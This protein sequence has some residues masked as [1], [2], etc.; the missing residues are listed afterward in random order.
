MNNTFTVEC[1]E[2]DEGLRLDQCIVRHVPDLH[3]SN[4]KAHA[5]QLIRDGVAVKLSSRVHS[6]EV[7][8]VSLQLPEP[9]ST[10]AENIPLDIIAEHPDYVVLHKPQGMVVHPGAGNSNGTL[11]HA[12][13]G[14]YRED[15]YFELNSD[16]VPETNRPGIVHRLDKETSGVMIVARTP[17][18]HIWLVDQFKSRAVRKEYV[19]IVKGVPTPAAADLSAALSRDPRNRIR[20]AVAGEMRVNST[21]EPSIPDGARS[22]RTR[23][24]V[25]ASY[26]D[27][28]A[29]IRLFPFTGRTH[30]LRVHMQYL[31]HPILGDPLYARADRRFAEERLMLHAR[32][33]TVVPRLGVAEETFAAAVPERFRRVLA[34]LSSREPV[35]IPPGNRGSASARP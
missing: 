19:A 10:T 17:K 11:V 28:Y 31:G 13:A 9:M 14:R 15:P 21:K 27:A 25:I 20:F 12:L 18:N 23:Y 7:I 29:L 30:Q 32:R 8:R 16:D 2:E 3:R 5:V 34:Q 1:T 33:L 26:G 35:T 24:E 22:A 6:G 4:L